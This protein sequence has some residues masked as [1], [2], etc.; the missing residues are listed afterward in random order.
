MECVLVVLGGQVGWGSGGES[1]RFL[2][3]FHSIHHF[4]MN[5]LDENNMPIWCAVGIYGW[6]EQ[7][8][9]NFTWSL[10]TTLKA[11]CNVPCIMFGDINEVVSLSEKDGGTTRSEW[12]MDAF[13]DAIDDCALRDLGF[14]GSIFTWKRG[15][16]M[17]TFVKR[18]ARH[19]FSG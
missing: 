14:K 19:I 4:S 16:S 3:F 8:N 5:V 9:K 11:T 12:L 18:A 17:A 10:R 6:P 1:C 15:T 7:A 2:Q 13:R